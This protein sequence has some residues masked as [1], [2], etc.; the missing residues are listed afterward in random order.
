MNSSTRTCESSFGQNILQK[1]TDM[2][3]LFVKIGCGGVASSRP[4]LLSFAM[5]LWKEVGDNDHL[6]GNGHVNYPCT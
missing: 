6:P 4:T 2:L 1:R 3:V 5:M